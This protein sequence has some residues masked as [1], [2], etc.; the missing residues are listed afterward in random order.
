MFSGKHD[1]SI[2][3]NQKTKKFVLTD[4]IISYDLETE[5]DSLDLSNYS[6]FMGDFVQDKTELFIAED[7]VN[8]IIDCLVCSKDMLR[9]DF[10]GFFVSKENSI[11]STDGHRLN[12]IKPSDKTFSLIGE[13]PYNPIVKP[14]VLTISK[15]LKTSVSLYF[16]S[17]GV[18]LKT[19][20]TISRYADN[21]IAI[22]SNIDGR[23][24]DFTK[25]V[26]IGFKTSLAI[27]LNQFESMIKRLPWLSRNKE[28]TLRIAC[29]KDLSCRIGNWNKIP[30]KVY[31]FDKSD[32]EFSASVNEFGLDP[33]YTLEATHAMSHFKDYAEMRIID[34]DSPV[35]MESDELTVVIMPKQI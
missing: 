4:T 28:N 8:A 23:F 33:F 34:K 5:I 22:I 17:S 2:I 16:Y 19:Y 27:N 30:G 26:P 6:D 1:S 35:V 21:T 15:A 13:L 20:K 25:V 12:A 11:V 32:A 18:K 9:P 24:P 29:L 10:T 14:E 7:N 31:T 3:F